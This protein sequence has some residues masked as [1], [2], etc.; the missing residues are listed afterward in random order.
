MSN[1]ADRRR[2]QRDAQKEEQLAKQA[3][4]RQFEKDVRRDGIFD[5]KAA[6]QNPHYMREIIAMRK[7]ERDGWDRNGI[8]KADLDREYQRGYKAAQKEMAAFY[9]KYFFASVAITLHRDFKF[10]KERIRRVL[11]A[12]YGDH[13]VGDH[14]MRHFEAMPG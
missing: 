2:A 6:W 8:T 9:G 10:G 13:D 5:A 7:S 11:D 1:R 14:D 4:A 12:M 3:A